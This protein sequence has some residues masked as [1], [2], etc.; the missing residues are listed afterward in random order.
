MGLLTVTLRALFSLS[1]PSLRRPPG[2]LPYATAQMASGFRMNTSAPF[3]DLPTSGVI[4]E[5][6]RYL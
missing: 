6:S 4:L 3:L 1:V 2:H 5:K